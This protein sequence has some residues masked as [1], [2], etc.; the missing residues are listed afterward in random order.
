VVNTH[1]VTPVAGGTITQDCVIQ[2]KPIVVNGQNLVQ[3]TS[4]CT[5]VFTP[6]GS[7]QETT[8]SG[9]DST[10]SSTDSN[11]SSA[12]SSSVATTSSASDSAQSSSSSSATPP[13]AASSA[14]DSTGASATTSASTAGTSGSA[15]ADNTSVA[16]TQLPPSNGSPGGAVSVVGTT[17]LSALQQMQT[18]T[19]ASAADTAPSQTGLPGKKLQVLPIGL[20]VFAGIS[21]IA[22]IVVGLVTYERTKY[23]KAFRQRRLAA[24]GAEMGYGGAGMSQRQ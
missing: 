23:R 12:Q 1:T 10:G 9:S 8:I 24:S 11:N 7:T 15:A 14:T 3:E 17:S 20:G 16:G 22:L 21:V 2:L 19:P 18:S 13:A 6:T 4:D 5:Q